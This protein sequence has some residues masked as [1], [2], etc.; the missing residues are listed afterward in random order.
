MHGMQE[1]MGSN[2]TI[3]MFKELCAKQIRTQLFSYRPLQVSDYKNHSA[4]SPVTVNAVN[5]YRQIEVTYANGMESFKYSLDSTF[6]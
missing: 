6:V 2:P 3:S 1:V 4:P 5:M